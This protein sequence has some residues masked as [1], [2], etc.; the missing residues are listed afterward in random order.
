[1]FLLTLILFS[2]NSKSNAGLLLEIVLIF[3]LTL[4][5][6]LISIELIIL[7]F[8]NYISKQYLINNTTLICLYFSFY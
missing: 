5:A 3:K 6:F 4:I 1:M 7:I 8:L 2:A